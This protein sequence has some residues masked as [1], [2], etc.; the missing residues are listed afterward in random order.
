[1]KSQLTKSEI[2][3]QA[4]KMVKIGYG[5]FSYCLSCAWA[6]SKKAA[7]MTKVQLSQAISNLSRLNNTGEYTFKIDVYKTALENF[8]KD[9]V[10]R[11]VLSEDYETKKAIQLFYS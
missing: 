7:S 2:F 10:I 1:M 5:S 4:W 6:I 9:T 11:T 3:K 8:P